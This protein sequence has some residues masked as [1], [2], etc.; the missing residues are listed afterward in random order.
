MKSVGVIII[1]E[2]YLLGGPQDIAYRKDR[3]ALYSRLSSLLH[4]PSMYLLI[5]TL[6]A[7]MVVFICAIALPMSPNTSHMMLFP[8]LQAITA[9]LVLGAIAA[10]SYRNSAT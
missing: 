3:V 4:P 7:V 1:R 8:L 10:F 9:L 2:V 5:A 6:I